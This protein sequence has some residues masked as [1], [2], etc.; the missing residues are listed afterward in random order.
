MEKCTRLEGFTLMGKLYSFVFGKKALWYESHYV[1]VRSHIY[2]YMGQLK[3]H[4]LTKKKNVAE[5]G[6]F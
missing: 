6:Y 4:R 1:L 5:L 2:I 3:I